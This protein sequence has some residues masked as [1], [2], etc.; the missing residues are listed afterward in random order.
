MH[1]NDNLRIPFPSYIDEREAFVKLRQ[2][3]QWFRERNIKYSLSYTPL[4][5]HIPTHIIMRNED[6]LIFKL[7]FNI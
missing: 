2:Y 7:V 3:K 6:A 1:I 4:W 5:A